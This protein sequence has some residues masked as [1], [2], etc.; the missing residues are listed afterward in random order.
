M[1]VVRALPTRGNNNQICEIG[2]GLFLTETFKI[3]I[4]CYISYRR[5]GGGE[6]QIWIV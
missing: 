6:V 2:F 3:V 1:V 4:L 5:A